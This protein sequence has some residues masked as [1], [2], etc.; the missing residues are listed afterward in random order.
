MHRH[1]KSIN[2]N[3]NFP[4]PVTQIDNQQPL[5]CSCVWHCPVVGSVSNHSDSRSARCNKPAK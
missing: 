1:T 3:T 5:Q 2:D 4:S